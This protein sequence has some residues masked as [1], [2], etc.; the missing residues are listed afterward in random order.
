MIGYHRDAGV[1]DQGIDLAGHG[2][3]WPYLRAP[4]GVFWLIMAPICALQVFLILADTPTW[5]RVSSAGVI[6][7]TLFA[8]ARGYV[9]RLVLM[10]EGVMLRS[11][12]SSR[13]IPWHRVSDVGVYVPGGG[14]GA[15]PYLFITTRSAPPAGKWDVDAETIQVQDRP[16]LLEAV[17]AFR[18]LARE[19]GKG[20]RG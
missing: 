10:P 5:I 13:H 16:G 17:R 15:T 12:F 20:A 2:T 1:N 7:M 14:L 11:L 18:A 9:R 6:L 8:Y 4:Q 19:A 3:T